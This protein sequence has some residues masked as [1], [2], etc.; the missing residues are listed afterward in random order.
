MIVIR[1]LCSMI[2]IRTSTQPP[3]GIHFADSDPT[4]NRETKSHDNHRA[5]GSSRNPCRGRE[6]SPPAI[7]FWAAQGRDFYQQ[8][9]QRLPAIIS[10]AGGWAEASSQR[11]RRALMILLPRRPERDLRI[12]Q[13]ATPC[14]GY[15]GQSRPRL[16]QLPGTDR[17]RSRTAQREPARFCLYLTRMRWCVSRSCQVEDEMCGKSE[18]I[19]L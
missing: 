5:V 19:M 7:L 15:Y 11:D 4:A 13:A 3:G 14:R 8:A 16:R 10:L 1:H 9:N 12:P 2:A 17:G 18:L 6:G